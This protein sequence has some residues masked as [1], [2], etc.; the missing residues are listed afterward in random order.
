MTSYVEAVEL[1]V[2]FC[3]ALRGINLQLNSPFRKLLWKSY[4]FN[5]LC[6]C[7]TERAFVSVSTSLQFFALFFLEKFNWNCLKHFFVVLILN[8]VKEQ[9]KVCGRFVELS[10]FICCVVLVYL[11]IWD[12]RSFNLIGK[13]VERI[14]EPLNEMF[15]IFSPVA[16]LN[17]CVLYISD[18]YNRLNGSKKC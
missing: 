17:L 11:R 4:I 9:I 12:A 5:G 15:V 13:M 10:F 16:A 18:F 14:Q 2:G 7:C 3:S 1:D 6:T 8:C